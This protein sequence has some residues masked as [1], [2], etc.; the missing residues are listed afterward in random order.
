MRYSALLSSL[1][2]SGAGWLIAQPGVAQPLPDCAPPRSNEYLLLVLHQRP[3]T[4]TQL[5][6][7]LP[8]NAVTTT[9]SYLEDQVVRVE[10][11]A[12]ADIANAWAQYVSDMTGLQAFVAR[13]AATS[14]SQVAPA[15]SAATSTT[16]FP[17]PTQISASGGTSSPAPAPIAQ[18]GAGSFP[19]PTQLPEVAPATPEATPIPDAAPAPNTDA[20]RS[21]NPQA[22]GTGYAVLV[23]YFNRPEVAADVRQV[24][25]QPVGLVSYEQRPFLLAAYTPD[26]AVAA[27]VLQS[28]S[29]RGFTAVMVDGRRTIL[30]TPAVIGTEGT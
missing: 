10:G 17:A 3:D 30:L 20:N 15:S 27:S 25:Q 22:L 23:Y 2:L 16:N 28:L 24:T 26:P 14:S 12:S 8:E 9:C 6:Q 7:L 4:E 13:P 21:Y 19:T 1:L 5:Q 11:F 29:D 18:N